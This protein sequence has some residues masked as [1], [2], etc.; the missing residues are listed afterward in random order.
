M[1]AANVYMTYCSIST[2]GSIPTGSAEN[3][4]NAAPERLRFIAARLD[5]QVALEKR[6]LMI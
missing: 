4:A 2:V 3:S 6:Y 1:G 5:G